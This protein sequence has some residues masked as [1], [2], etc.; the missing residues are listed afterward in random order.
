MNREQNLRERVREAAAARRPLN[1]S[2]GGSKAFLGRLA[3]G[4]RLDVARHRGILDYEPRELVITARCGTPLTE[5]ETTLAEQG[6]MLPFEPPHFADTATLGGCIAA[7]LSGPRRPFS[8]AARDLLL[9]VRLLNGRGEILRFG[10]AVMKN[11]AGYDIPRLMCGALGTL[12]VLLEVSLKV[13]P[14]P[15]RE[16]TLV[17]DEGPVEALRRF[18]DCAGGALPLSGA[19]HDGKRSYLRLSGA[20]SAVAAAR[21]TLGGERLEAGEDF[22]R[23][24]V[25][26]QGHRFFRGA[27][28][29]WRLS[30]PPAAPWDPR[31]GDTFIDWGGA[32]RWIRSERPPETHFSAASAAGGHASLFRGG[33]RQGQ[34]RQPLP[35]AVM[36]IQHR[37]KQAF[38]PQGLFNPRR[39]YREF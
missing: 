37:L 11:V 6:Q 24:Q 7:G 33:D 29:L 23:R 19:C 27:A 39:L 16:I 17:Y 18:N 12:G 10:G 22:W 26:E 3:E 14:L 35:T 4:E 20:E 2:G 15:P 38:D 1:I 8:G 30:L 21:K 5:I 13:L 36:T 9:G 28:P 25:R 32:L 34:R 31:P